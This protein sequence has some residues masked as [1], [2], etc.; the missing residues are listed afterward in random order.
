MKRMLFL[1][2]VLVCFAGRAKAQSEI[3]HLAADPATCDNTRG[4]LYFNTTTGKI[5][6]CTALNTWSDT[7]GSPNTVGPVINV[8]N[9]AYGASSALADNA[10]AFTAVAAAANAAAY[11]SVGTPTIRSTVKTVMST[12]TISSAV[13]TVNISAGDTVLIGTIALNAPAVLTYTVSDGVN[14]YYPVNLNSSPAGTFNEQIQVFGTV[15]GAA[16]AFSGTLTVTISSGGPA[17]F[18]FIVL[19]AFNVGSYGQTNL[20]GSASSNATPTVTAM[21]QDNNNIIATWV[22][23]CNAAGVTISQNTGTLQQSWN[24][25]A[26][27]C[28]AGLV[29]NTAASLNTNLVTSASLSAGSTWAVNG[30]ELRSVTTSIPTVY[31]PVGRYVYTSGLNFLNAVTLKG[32]P[33]AVLCYAGA[34]HAIDL[35]PAGLTFATLQSDYY[36]VDGLRFEC[37]AGMTQ[38]I[39][40]ANNVIYVEIK[41]NDFNNFGNT[42]AAAIFSNGDTE[43]LSIKLNKFL[44]FDGPPAPANVPSR[45]FVDVTTNAAFSTLTMTNNYAAC[46]AGKLNAGVG[47]GTTSGPLISTQGYANIISDNSIGGGFCPAIDLRGG[48]PAAAS[49]RI[50]NNNFETDQSG[51]YAITYMLNLDGLKVLNNFFSF[52]AAGTALLGPKDG[53]QLLAN[54]E[55]S[56]NVIVNIPINNPVVIQNNLAGQTNNTGWHNTCS[57]AQ[58]SGTTPCALLHTLG[59]N[60]NQWNNDYSG[61][62]TLVNPTGCPAY[63]FLVTYAVAPKCTASWNGTGAFTGILKVVPSTTQLK[64]DSTVT[65]DTGVVNWACN[66]DAQ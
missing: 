61:T 3:A 13:A 53:T 14:T 51:C 65:T 59:G 47:C 58:V 56:N 20:F 50:Q 46:V 19:D 55:V 1:F 9:P 27:I 25:T 30:I 24:S 63:N 36:I 43:D 28:G 32:E 4:L 11:A 34:A 52:K 44:I 31:F 54:A 57:T 60:I 41:N 66:P 38:G 42:T 48:N 5:R 6:S 17:Q 49:T 22:D 8:T 62:C 18:G 15:P 23:Y 26:V 40:L 16:K 21:T 45:K 35:G 12:S 64:I 10:T 37:G 39:F 2:A 7:S 33:G 29:T